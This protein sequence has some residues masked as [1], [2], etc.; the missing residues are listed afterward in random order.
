MTPPLANDTTVANDT[1]VDDDTAVAE[2]DPVEFFAVDL[3]VVDGR[4]A[5]VD[6]DV[7]AGLQDFEGG[8]VERACD[9]FW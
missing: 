5:G 8:V 7:I 9:G 2:V 6:E 1:P 3:D 4:L